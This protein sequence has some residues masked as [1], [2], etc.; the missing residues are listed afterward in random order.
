MRLVGRSSG[1]G[2]EEVGNYV[3]GI[4]PGARL[5]KG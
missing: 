1:G 2:V 3:R 4:G 5:G